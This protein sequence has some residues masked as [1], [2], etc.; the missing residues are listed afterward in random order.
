MAAA[1]KSGK[2]MTDEELVS[3]LSTRVRMATGTTDSRLSRERE[4]HARYYDGMEPK[5]LHSG[6]SSYVSQDVF[7]SV[8]AMKAQLLETFTGNATPVHFTPSGAEDVE[9][10]RIA[11]EYSNFVVFRQNAGFN[12]MNDVI[13]DGLMNRVGIAQVYWR[14]DVQWIEEAMPPVPA[15]AA[16]ATMQEIAA[17]GPSESRRR[18]IKHNEDGTVSISYER[19][20]DRSQVVIE[21]LAPEEF[22]ISPRAR[23]METAEVKF[24]SAQ[25]SKSALIKEGYPKS[26]IEDIWNDDSVWTDTN[27]EV[28]QRFSDTDDASY[29]GLNDEIQDARR[30]IRVYEVYCHLDM[31]GAG[32]SELYKVTYGGNQI[33]DKERVSSQPFLSFAPLRK[34]HSFWGSSFAGKVVPTQ[35]AKTLLKRAIID[36]A[37]ITTNPRYTVV[38]GGLVNPK[39]LLENRIGGLINITRDNA[40]QPL[41]QA[42]LN[43]FI[44][45]TIQELDN[46]KEQLTAVSKLSQGLNKDVISKQNSAD[47]V[48][49]M[50]GSSQT[51]QKVI[52]RNFATNFMAELF[53]KVYQLVI[54]NE[55]G[56]KVKQ[57]AGNWV[58]IDPENWAERKDVSVEFAVGYGEQDKERQKWAETHAALSQVEALRQSYGPAQQFKVISKALQASGIKDVET[59]LLNPAQ[60]PKPQ[61]D[62]VQTAI[63]QIPLREIALKE[64]HQKAAEGKTMSDVQ[65]KMQETGLKATRESGN[66]GAEDRKLTLD[67]QKFHHQMVVD[68]A[69]IALQRQA[70]T[71]TANPEPK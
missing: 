41:L 55:K 33:L 48:Q 38:R 56:E 51:R 34:P 27:P 23:D 71:I 13:H 62:P 44:L 37:V 1:T 42:P 39:E 49:T 15:T 19:R 4:T 50:M 16:A 10:A 58:Q 32:T 64:A 53:L 68:A 45:P 35:N 26:T 60:A 43:Q 14:K 24:R 20:E 40:V 59:Y 17:K 67:E 5:R 30:T 47:M 18:K 66:M 69:E 12:V 36:H 61:P 8:E 65:R 29:L 22:G 25:K 70:T 57:I 7:D 3:W 2:P 21:C 31:A 11:T 63:A 9:A 46:D 52:A 54:E 28:V 6:S